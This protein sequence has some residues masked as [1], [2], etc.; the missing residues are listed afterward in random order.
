MVLKI[1]TATDILKA[2]ADVYAKRRVPLFSGNEE[3]NAP[4]ST[5]GKLESY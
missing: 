5:V 1:Q 4:E 3:T 2:C